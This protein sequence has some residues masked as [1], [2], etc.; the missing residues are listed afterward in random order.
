[1]FKRLLLCAFVLYLPLLSFG[2]STPDTIV[3]Q[4]FNFD[5]YKT[6][7]YKGWVKCPPKDTE[8]Q[9]IWMKY[10]LRCPPRQCGEWDYLAYIFLNQYTGKKDTNWAT[11]PSFRVGDA[12][13]D[14][15]IYRTDTA[16]TYRYNTQ[17][18][19]VD[20]LPQAALILIL[21][22]DST[23]PT[24]ATD[25]LLVWPPYYRIRF[26]ENGLKTDSSLIQ[27][28][29]QRI[30]QRRWRTT[31]TLS[32][33]FIR[34][35]LG[36]YITP[37][38]NSLFPPWEHTHWYDWTDYRPLLVDSAYID[39]NSLFYPWIPGGW[40]QYLEMTLYFVVG[41]PAR[42]PIKVENVWNGYMNYGDP[43]LPID[44]RFKPYTVRMPDEAGS[45]RLKLRSTG[46]GFGGNENCSE[47]CPKTHSLF[48]NNQLAYDHTVW[49]DNCGFNPVYP[50]AGTW[51]FDRAG[52]CP[53]ADVKTNDVELDAYRN[54]AKTFNI[55]YQHEDYTWNG[56]G[57]TPYYLFE[58]QLIYYAPDEFTTDVAV[59][60]ILA[61]SNQPDHLR[62]NPICN[63][64]TIA[65]QNNGLDTLRQLSIIYGVSGQRQQ[66]FEW[67]GTLLPRASQE[68]TLPP[69]VWGI[70]S[71]ES[72]FQVQVNT[73]PPTNDENPS[74]NFMQS[75]FRLPERLDSLI[76]LRIQT[77]LGGRHN[78]Y[79]VKNVNGRVLYERKRGRMLAD[80]LYRDTF[81][82]DKGCY[83]L[84]ILDAAG[85]GLDFFANRDGRGR[86]AIT[87][88]GATRRNINLEPNFGTK[89]GLNFTVG[90][91]L[92]ND[93]SNYF[94]SRPQVNG[95]PALGFS[96]YP[97][98]AQN[99]VTLEFEQGYANGQPLNLRIIDALGRTVQQDRLS[100]ALVGQHTIDTSAL[101]N[102][103]YV[104]E[105][106]REDQ[107]TRQ[108]LL[109]LRP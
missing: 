53:G 14:S 33:N 15:F 23:R 78:S 65:V 12:A 62:L 24:E 101:P 57:S 94:V 104:V 7:G 70:W 42:K 84:E 85:D 18:Q 52:W 77:N 47:F 55:R 91:H 60:D 96:L 38:G 45:V 71:D 72:P 106:S 75:R 2:Q 95:Q 83:T 40:S 26:N 19:M 39:A 54:G 36:R 99:R 11:T 41:K 28:G 102:G 82:L 48:V 20:S 73:V 98:P 1:L 13:P 86:I 66:T 80:E 30:K 9:K 8:I 92:N 17:T 25:T 32:D 74:N 88:I 50:Q 43:K 108:K 5:D 61:P 4:A 31:Y 68:I 64:P 6:N 27:T 109:L 3:V 16:Y 89:T 59:L 93:T 67:Q 97:N 100:P 10:R 103:M 107:T 76:V 44:D 105:L 22:S 90:Y 29:Q 63:N 51:L 49:R 87:S 21:F 56:Q 58:S 69:F 34:Y 37:Y 35:E 81:L 46:H 79:T